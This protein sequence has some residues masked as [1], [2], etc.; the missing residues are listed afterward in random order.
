MV[1]GSP[2]IWTVQLDPGL[3]RDKAKKALVKCVVFS[4]LAP[5][6]EG[7][8]IGTGCVFGQE[9]LKNHRYRAVLLPWLLAHSRSMRYRPVSSMSY[10]LRRELP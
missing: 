4:A 2:G 8:G 5:L 6:N 10:L 9:P 1:V 7:I 3:G